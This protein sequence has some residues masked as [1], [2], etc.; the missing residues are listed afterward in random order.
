MA[1]EAWKR[2]SYTFDIEWTREYPTE[3]HLSIHINNYRINLVHIQS[4]SDGPGA[5]KQ[6]FELN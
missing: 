4:R 3:R 6:Q 2:I 1:D 5:L